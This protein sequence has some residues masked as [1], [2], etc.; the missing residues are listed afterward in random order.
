MS[1][2]IIQLIAYYASLGVTG[3]YFSGTIITEQSHFL[4]FADEID[5]LDPH[6]W[7][8]DVIWSEDA[9][10][11]LYISKDPGDSVIISAALILDFYSMGP[12]DNT[13]LFGG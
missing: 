6:D 11:I 12:V 2:G 13:R 9:Q 7:S 8:G 5:P 10:A 1:W 3:K 4:R